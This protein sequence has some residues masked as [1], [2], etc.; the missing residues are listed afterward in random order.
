M[1]RR[2]QGDKP[3]QPGLDFG[4]GASAA[5]EPALLHPDPLAATPAAGKPAD[6]GVAPKTS[7]TVELHA[8][9]V[10]G[11]AQPV[12]DPDPDADLR[13]LREL[14]QDITV[15]NRRYHTEDAQTIS[16]ADYDALMA[17][18]LA[19]EARH[20]EWITPDSP[21]QRV[22]A[23]TSSTFQSVRHSRPMLSLING[24]EDDDVLAFDKRVSD[25]L[26]EAGL[27]GLAEDAEYAVEYKFDGVAVS[28]RYER[29]A[30][31]QAATR[32]D[33][34]A[35]EDIT[36]NVRTLHALGTVPLQLGPGAPEVLEVRGEVLMYRADFDALND[37]QRVR[38]DK[39]FVN[40]RNASAGS[41]RQLD[42]SITA[43]RPLRFMAYGWGEISTLPEGVTTHAAL[44]DWLS[45][46]GLHVS[47]A[48]R[49][50]RG[51]QGLLGFYQET[52]KA[53]LTLP[54]DIDGV[55][56]KVNSLEAQQVLGQ[57]ARA[58]RYA[59]AHKFPAQEAFTEVLAI[60]HQVGR[61]GAITPVAR[62]KPV[63]VGGV[64]VTN[65]TLHNE[66]EIRRKGVS[67][68][69]K[70]IVRRAGDVIPEIVSVAHALGPLVQAPVRAGVRQ[71][72]R[73]LRSGKRTGRGV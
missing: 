25:T 9:R 38:G 13:R 27:L 18:L 56:Y 71:L 45:G 52:G 20:P 39:V 4:D 69:D 35:G 16:D 70:V 5:P 30:L 21:T 55:V 32:G 15:H 68:G 67:V 28:I 1:T 44:L 23:E 6:E 19:I 42:S 64:T 54:Y 60:E 65:A 37:A 2:S 62:L 72:N 40:P 31:V 10:D 73:Q 57:V 50:V 7:D 36:A 63:F 61:T 58:P 51:A 8:T 33:G 26:R 47:Q 24:F 49:I 3:A 43:Q 11:D 22:G 59:L 53:R 66:S 41:L 48:R 12:A 29:G 46:L 14:R 17:E 34:Q